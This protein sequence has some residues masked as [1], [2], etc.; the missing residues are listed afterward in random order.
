MLRNYYT[1]LNKMQD[2]KKIYLVGILY[3]I[4]LKNITILSNLASQL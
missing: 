1:F 2:N 3:Y 4:S